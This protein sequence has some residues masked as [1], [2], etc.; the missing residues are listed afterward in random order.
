MVK[1]T[2]TSVQLMRELFATN[3]DGFFDLKLFLKTTHLQLLRPNVDLPRL[4]LQRSHD[5]FEG[6]SP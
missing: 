2:S 1:G 4:R 3:A 5:G 6:P